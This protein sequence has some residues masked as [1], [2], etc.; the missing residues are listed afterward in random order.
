MDCVAEKTCFKCSRLLPISDFYRH[1]RMSDGTLNKCKECTRNDVSTNYRKRHGYYA[2]Y[3]LERKRR[4]ERKLQ[5]KEYKKRRRQRNP[6]KD[7]ARNKLS[8][9]IRDGR[10]IRPE[11][12]QMCGK[13]CKPEAHH[14]DYSR[15]LDVLWLCFICH[16]THG[17]GQSPVIN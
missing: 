12:C 2:A 3:E 14:T 6:D 8:N 10:V 7:K 9:A 4:P 1:K 5:K 11:M 16:R 13:S 17:H 15:P